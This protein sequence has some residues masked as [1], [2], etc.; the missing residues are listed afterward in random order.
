MPHIVSLTSHGS[1]SKKHRPNSMELFCILYNTCFRFHTYLLHRC[2]DGGGCDAGYASQLHFASYPS[3]ALLLL[4]VVRPSGWQFP[5]QNPL[6][7][8]DLASAWEIGWT[9]GDDHLGGAGLGEGQR[10]G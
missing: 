4:P 7:L 6:P 10:E 3:V 9:G 5:S 8:G 2:D 1:E